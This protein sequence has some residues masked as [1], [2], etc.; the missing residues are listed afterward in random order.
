MLHHLSITNY[1]LIDRAEIEIERGFTV[2]TGESGSGKSILLEALGLVL[3][4]RA[5]FNAIR[6]GQTKAVVE[7]EF[8]HLSIPM[9]EFL[10]VHGLDIMPA[11]TLRRELTIEGRSRAFINDSPVNLQTMRE[12]GRLLVD[13]HGQQ[14]NMALQTEHYQCRQLDDYAGNA[15]LYA[16]YTELYQRWKQTTRD[17]E[18]M[19]EKAAQ[20]RKDQDYFTF[21][22]EE[23]QGLKLDA[24]AFSALEGELKQLEHAEDIL[25]ALNRLE[26]M[27]GGDEGGVLSVLKNAQH[28]SQGIASF[29]SDLNEISERI[30]SVRIELDDLL[31]SILAQK[32]RVE[33]NPDRMD[34][35][36]LQLDELNRL[37]YKHGA[38]DLAALEAVRS[39]YKSKLD[40]IENFDAQLEALVREEEK[41]KADVLS[42][43]SELTLKRTKSAKPFMR[44]LVDTV[45][46]L[47]MPKAHFN[48]VLTPREAPGILGMESV[49][50]RFN[51]NGKDDLAPL[52]EVASGGEISRLML[53]LKSIQKKVGEGVTLVFDEI[54]T[55]VSGEVAKRIGQLMKNLGQSNQ[56]IAVTHLP[57]VAARGDHHIRAFKE[58]HQ[59]T[60]VSR[61]VALKPS[62]RVEELAAMFSGNK[63]TDASLE[64]ARNLLADEN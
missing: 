9:R 61:F 44:A 1:A 25:S 22:W 2:M 18:A 36:R 34:T 46:E 26:A 15:S 12:A 55:G 58:E 41:C 62:D 48:V 37:M 39:D 24:N 16:K 29:S 10:Q 11:L 60:Y 33:L 47:G 42:A 57:G 63:L 32:E 54:D 30:K 64:S 43:A 7:A 6:K 27:I 40:G 23:L 50:M 13:L 56:V 28:E 35:V 45:H 8:D 49:E 20:I 5:N 31:D 17:L 38:A 21:Q 53:A 51:A 14:E 4:G 3:G 19:R 52:H 59:K